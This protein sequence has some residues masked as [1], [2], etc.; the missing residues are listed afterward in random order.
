MDMTALHA[1]SRLL[2]TIGIVIVFSV[3]GAM[4]A[5]ESD[6][7]GKS[8]SGSI[9]PNPVKGT[10]N[11]TL[12]RSTLA[13]PGKIIA[14]P[15]ADCSP[16]AISSARQLPSGALRQNYLFRIPTRGGVAPVSFSL[17]NQHHLPPGLK[18][19]TNG[20]IAGLPQKPGTYAFTIAVSDSCQ[21]GS[22]HMEKPFI[23]IINDAMPS[24]METQ[25]ALSHQTLEN[26]GIE[27]GLNIT[28]LTLAFAGGNARIVMAKEQEVP[29]LIAHFQLQGSGVIAGY[30]VTPA[31]EKLFFK[32][33]VSSPE[34]TLTFPANNVLPMDVPGQHSIRMVLT[35]PEKTFP[36]AVASYVVMRETLP[37]KDV[38][39]RQLLVT[40]DL[41]AKD[42][43]A[44]ILG[45][46]Y[47]LRLRES[48]ALT[49]LASAILVFETDGDIVALA[50]KIES[51]PGVMMAQ[52][53]HVFHTLSEPNEALQSL[54]RQLWFSKIHDF[55]RGRGVT[56]AVIDTGVDVDHEDLQANIRGAENFISGESYHAEIHG[57]AVAGIIAAGINYNGIAGV[58][59]EASILALRACKQVSE[60]DPQGR[61]N[62]VSIAR[63]IDA[64]V[65]HK[66]GIV[67]MSFGS[68][69]SDRLIARLIEVGV[70]R[71]ILFVAPVG[72]REGLS[73]PTFPA[74]LE[75]VIAVGGVRGN[76]EAFPSPALAAAATVCAPCEHLFTTIP[77]NRYN[78]LDGTSISTAV[79]SG[80]LA[81]VL[82]KRRVLRKEDLPST[83][84]DIRLWTET[85]LGI[86][87][88]E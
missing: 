88:S 46:R 6:I 64:A 16:F 60:A 83:S 76:G 33:R 72:N 81:L 65:S 87:L 7:T 74:S 47:G 31:K 22:R 57:T 77:G 10:I 54:S 56:V 19:A 12:S 70:R 38:V 55:S 9:L 85:L 20:L 62:S 11:P 78:F 50:E 34:A 3:A 21:Q 18:L 69:T 58:A 23:M 36:G 43:L 84:N 71:G 53:N 5:D 68:G 24:A 49:S 61:G 79:V 86:S 28:H 80:V 63:A 30:W 75:R 15:V 44:S 73:V 41:K 52:P 2:M 8:R 29:A 27:S 17:V 42:S 32:K 35:S 48:Y 26:P 67:N 39:S 66:V 45:T 40:V 25:T 4:A 14:V 51:E 13:S 59:P 82:E 37:P 1:R